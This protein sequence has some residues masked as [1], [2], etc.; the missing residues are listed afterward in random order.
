MKEIDIAIDPEVVLDQLTAS[1]IVEYLGAGDMLDAV[2][3][4]KDVADVVN[5]LGSG[6]LLDAIGLTEIKDWL[7]DN[8]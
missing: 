8:A 1:D 5:Q 3:E 7:A 2:L 4:V 6:D